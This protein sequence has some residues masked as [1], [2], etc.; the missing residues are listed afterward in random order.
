M[1]N[2]KTL[3]DLDLNGRRA[4]VRVDLNVP[5]N[6][7]KITDQ[8]RAERIIPTIEEILE[9]GAGVILASHLGRPNGKVVS[10][11]SLEPLMPILQILMPNRNITFSPNGN[12]E[13]KSG[14]II[15]LENLRFNLGEENNDQDFSKF[16][17]GLADVYINDAFSC[18]HRAHASTE[19]ITHLLPSAAG[20]L[21]EGELQALD[22]ALDNPIHPVVAVVG[23]NKISTKLG[24]L[25]NLLKKVDHLIVAG[26]MA[27]TFLYALGNS[28]GQSVCEESMANVA[29]DV[30]ENA[31]L[32]D[33]KIH[34]PLDAILAEKLED[35]P[36]TIVAKKNSIPSDLMILDI[37]PDTISS[38]IT[39]L[40]NSKTLLWNGPLGAF[41]FKPFD[42]ATNCVAQVAANLTTKSQLTTI[43]GGGDTMAALKNAQVS[44]SFSYLSSAGGAFLEWLEGK[45][46]PGVV[47]LLNE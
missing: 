43:A 17:S 35:N 31:K 33:C 19:G 12:K 9:K 2:F 30:I 36:K 10:D 45:K 23:G 16:L 6:K 21:M 29:L 15:L 5:M 42:N 4:L 13:P 14:E 32:L 44:D 20:R 18:S 27:N 39:L 3:D 28:V 7:G 34:L 40:N 22:Q 26:A 41:E 46:L 38:I 37:G 47:P 11:Y 1:V 25:E 24:V 8:T